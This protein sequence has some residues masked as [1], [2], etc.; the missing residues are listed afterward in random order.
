MYHE[1]SHSA[2]V[3]AAGPGTQKFFFSSSAADHAQRLGPNSQYKTKI[4]KAET[5]WNPC[6]TVDKK[7]GKNKRQDQE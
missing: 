1:R 7:G 4:N 2:P 6:A 5:H 3:L